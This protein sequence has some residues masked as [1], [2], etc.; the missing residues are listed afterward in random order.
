MLWEW[1]ASIYFYKSIPDKK[2][3]ISILILLMVSVVLKRVI[4]AKEKHITSG[5]PLTQDAIVALYKVNLLPR[6]HPWL[7]G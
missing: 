7:G 4:S 2:S 1:I 5:S 3:R 6:L